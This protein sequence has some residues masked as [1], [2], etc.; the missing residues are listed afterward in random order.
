[1]SFC[2]EVFLGGGEVQHSIMLE[3]QQLKYI[4]IYIF[5]KK[6]LMK[7][8]KEKKIPQQASNPQCSNYLT[9]ASLTVYDT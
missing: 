8:R 5:K 4:Y 2:Q 1:M 3:L 9:R 6:N 7:G